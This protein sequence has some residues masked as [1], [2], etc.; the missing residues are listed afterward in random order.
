[1][2]INYGYIPFPT[3]EIKCLNKGQKL[4]DGMIDYL[5]NKIFNQLNLNEKYHYI[6]TYFHMIEQIDWKKYK[7]FEKTFIV[8]NQDNHWFL[9][10]YEPKKL[11]F[12]LYDPLPSEDESVI[13]IELLPIGDDD[14]IE[15]YY[16]IIGNQGKSKTNCGIFVLLYVIGLLTKQNLSFN[17]DEKY[18]NNIIRKKF[19][20]FLNDEITV[21]K[22]F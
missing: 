7:N 10:V 1:M 9:F 16:G 13:D 5:I 19:I 12:H 4:T 14:I 15:D 11:K 17:Y 22:I 18:I 21:D 3:Y 2:L 8:L 20:Q 6:P